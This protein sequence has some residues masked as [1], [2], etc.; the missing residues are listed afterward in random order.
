[1]PRRI[2]DLSQDI[3]QGMPVHPRHCR[4]YIFANISR[5]EYVRQVGYPF[6]T[7]NILMNEHGPTH[8]D[9]I[10]EYAPDGPTIDQMPL[11]S[12]C[13]SAICLDLSHIPTD[14]FITRQ[15]LE[16]AVTKSGLSIQKGDIVL[17]HTGHYAAKYGS[18]AYLTDYTGID[19]GA[20]EWLADQSVVNVAVDAPSIDHPADPKFSAHA[21]CAER[22]LTNTEHLK[23]R[24]A[25]RTALQYF[26]LPQ[27]HWDWFTIRDCNPLRLIDE[28]PECYCDS[29][30]PT[31][32]LTLCDG[33]IQ[34]KH[35]HSSE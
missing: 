22:G 11:E 30:H 5:E 3:F 17:I 12:F 34:G 9:A 15:D 20:M 28:Q 33:S 21:V 32:E 6:Y 13:G 16:E 18:P 14:R 19:R 27:D 26:G 10:N 23:T 35:L 1:M 31:K 4:T 24:S 29:Q 8:S 7:R 25:C 2:I